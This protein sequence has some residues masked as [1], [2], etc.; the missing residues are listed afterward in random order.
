[1]S[2]PGAPPARAV[3][4][5]RK[6]DPRPLVLVCR[7]PDGLVAAIREAKARAKRPKVRV[8]AE[9][10]EEADQELEPASEQR[11]ER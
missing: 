7:D 3:R 2:A 5:V 11:R 9:P 6:S 8:D 4:I 1:M 10:A